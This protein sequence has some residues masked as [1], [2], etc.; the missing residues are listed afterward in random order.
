MKIFS[1]DKL[2][3]CGSVAIDYKDKI[4]TD[5]E[6]CEFLSFYLFFDLGLTAKVLTISANS[7]CFN[8]IGYDYDLNRFY[9]SEDI[10]SYHSDNENSVSDWLSIIYDSNEEFFN[11]VNQV[12]VE[13]TYGKSKP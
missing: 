12:L 4:I 2:I 8:H 11:M 6:Y 3:L 13:N 9:A 5:F 7:A 1:N 10:Y